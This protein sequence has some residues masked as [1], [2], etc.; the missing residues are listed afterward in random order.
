MITPKLI[1]SGGQTGADQ[2]GL[3]AAYKLEI[4]TAGFCPERCWTEEGPRPDL[5]ALYRLIEVEG[6]YDYE[7]RTRRNVEYAQA[8]VI[9]GKRSRGSNLT[10]RLCKEYGRPMLWIRLAVPLEPFAKLRLWLARYQPNT[11][12]IAGNRESVNPGIGAL[13]EWYLVNALR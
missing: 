5:M 1:I 12:N 2:A 11:L 7:P 13:V 4:P 10:E 3:R 9:F 8:T 6:R